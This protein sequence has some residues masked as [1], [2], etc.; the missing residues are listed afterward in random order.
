MYYSTYS[1]P[2]GLITLASDG[3]SLC[4]LWSEENRHIYENMEK[5]DSLLVFDMTK[6]WLNKYFKG[7]KPSVKEI[8][9][10]PIG[11]KFRQIVWALLLE[12]PYGE[13]TTYGEL[14][15]RVKVVLGI[16]KMSSRA[17]GGAVGHNP[18]SI[19]IPCHRVIG[20]SGNLTGYSGGLVNKIRLL[21][22]EGVKTNQFHIP[23]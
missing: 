15:E 5:D 11:T 23:N 6:E 1:S 22:H 21:E 20:K 10:A 16:S 19:I 17:I 14:S 9:L 7:E 2:I 3:K 13:T 4:G 8:P 18:I 12:I